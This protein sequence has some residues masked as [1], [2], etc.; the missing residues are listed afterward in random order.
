MIT[1]KEAIVSKKTAYVLKDLKPAGGKSRRDRP[2]QLETQSK[3]VG[4]RPPR[5]PWGRWGMYRT[6]SEGRQAAASLARKYTFADWRLIDTRT[7]NEVL[8]EVED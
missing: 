6:E 7:G 4:G 3:P 8:L 5:R 2:Y 1:Y